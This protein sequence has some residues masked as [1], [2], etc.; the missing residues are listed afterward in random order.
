M[1]AKNRPNI[2]TIN[3]FAKVVGLSY[4]PARIL[5]ME[6]FEELKKPLGG[7]WGTLICT[8]EVDESLY[9]GD[10]YEDLLEYYDFEDLRG[11]LPK[12]VE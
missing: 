1:M 8:D 4:R 6:M 12:L 3:A 7:F 5:R 11:Q 10:R 9:I 2:V